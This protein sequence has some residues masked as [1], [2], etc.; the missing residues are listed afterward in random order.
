M[1]YVKQKVRKLVVATCSSV[2]I[3]RHAVTWQAPVG[4]PAVAVCAMLGPL[5]GCLGWSLVSLFA[6]LAPILDPPR[7][8]RANSCTSHFS[9]SLPILPVLSYTPHCRSVLVVLLSFFAFLFCFLHHQHTGS[10][11]HSFK[12]IHHTHFSLLNF[13]FPFQRSF[14]AC[15]LRHLLELELT[16]DNR[17]FIHLQLRPANIYNYQYTNSTDSKAE[18]SAPRYLAI[19]IPIFTNLCHLLRATGPLRNVKLFCLDNTTAAL[20]SKC[21]PR[22]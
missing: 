8:L 7:P 1:Y 22:I 2:V 19:H 15:T 11:F 4:S 18:R 17:L 16:L 20:S 13:P 10:A 14:Y 12:A 6:D 5:V 21:R 3:K 9:L